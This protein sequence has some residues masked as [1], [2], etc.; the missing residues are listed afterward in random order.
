MLVKVAVTLEE[1]YSGAEKAATFVW[2]KPCAG[3]HGGGCKAG[4]SAA[5][6]RD[7][8]GAG[9]IVKVQQLGPGFIQQMAAPCTTCHG[10]GEFIVKADRCDKCH[11]NRTV[12]TD[13]KVQVK[14]PKGAYSGSRLHPVDGKSSFGPKGDAVVFVLEQLP[15]AFFERRGH[16][17]VGRKSV[18]LLQALT[19]L[20]F[21]LEG[22]DGKQI[23]VIS[24]AN[25]V[26]KPGSTMRFA[27]Q[28]LPKIDKPD[29]ERGDL[30]LQIDV[31]FPKTIPSQI[32]HILKRCLPE[33]ISAPTPNQEEK[34]KGMELTAVSIETAEAAKLVQ[35]A[36][37][38]QQ[39]HQHQQHPININPNDSDCRTM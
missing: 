8:R 32:Q 12:K 9:V 6:C 4:K 27:S 34:A 11:G 20:N 30:F 23:R 25:A 2:D 36:L 28:G 5:K 33:P 19:G 1:I 22:V 16:V 17:L 37:H 7:C 3:C 39:Q 10:L 13:E 15:H 21:V 26:T 18:S 35:E 38:Q 31:E 14:V 29:D 24:P